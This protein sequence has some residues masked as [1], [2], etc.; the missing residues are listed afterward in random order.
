MAF[1]MRVPTLV[2]VE[3]D[4]ATDETHAAITMRRADADLFMWLRS[5]KENGK[6]YKLFELKEI[7]LEY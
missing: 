3:Y 2:L 7:P 5:K 1:M 4:P 6:E